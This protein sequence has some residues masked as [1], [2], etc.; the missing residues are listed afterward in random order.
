MR[1]STLWQ[2]LIDPAG[3]RHPALGGIVPVEGGRM[4]FLADGPSERPTTA[5]T[6][7]LLGEPIGSMPQG[8][9]GC[10]GRDRG[11]TR[12]EIRGEIRGESWGEAPG[13]GRIQGR[14]EGDGAGDMRRSARTAAARRRGRA[15][16]LA[17]APG[18]PHGMAEDCLD[19]GQPGGLPVLMLHGGSGN[20][21]DMA[22]TLVPALARRHRVIAV[23]RPGFGHSDSVLRAA[24]L[25]GQVRALRAAMRRLGHR[26]VHLVGHSYGGAV[27]LA[28]ALNHREEVAT[29]S[30][31]SAASM[32]WG[33]TLDWQY[34]LTAAPLLG[35]ALAQAARFAGSRRI[36]AAL[37]AV[38]HP[39]PVPPAYRALGGVDLA[40]RP[41]TF[42]L[43]ARQIASLHPQLVDMVP[44][45]ATL[46]M[47][48]AVI[49]GTD[50]RVLPAAVHAVPLAARLPCGEPVLIPGAGHMPHHSH[51][52]LVAEAVSRTIARAPR[53]A[54]PRSGPRPRDRRAPRGA[55]GPARGG[56][57]PGSAALGTTPGR[58]RTAQRCGMVSRRCPARPP[59]RRGSHRR[60]SA[61]PRARTLRSAQAEPGAPRPR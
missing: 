43:N 23:D 24:S 36:G 11:E 60:E 47:P 58:N 54:A 27:A 57:L 42:R 30:L 51:T 52:A 20:L 55:P 9:A 22:M 34:R 41:S 49:H 5:A 61:R 48:A 33:G 6:P 16:F 40:L 45:Y 31:I 25:G 50:D 14:R 12:G 44:R 1:E 7:L 18:G 53:P 28:W 56:S 21:R 13:E 32:D 38:F 10:E 37:E 4:H 39:D 2:R 35:A 26:R 3:G 8:K 15:A 59:R 17:A 46:T 19:A 29:L